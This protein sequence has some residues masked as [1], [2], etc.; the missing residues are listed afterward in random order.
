MS[1]VVDRISPSFYLFGRSWPQTEKMALTISSNSNCLQCKPIG[2]IKICYVHLY[3]QY[4]FS[5]EINIC[6]CEK[7]PGLVLHCLWGF[8]ADF[9]PLWCS[10]T[11][12][13]SS[14]HP[15][16]SEIGAGTAHKIKY[17]W[18]DKGKYLF[19]VVISLSLAPFGAPILRCIW[20][21]QHILNW[22]QNR[23]IWHQNRLLNQQR[24][25]GQGKT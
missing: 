5:L 2:D 25:I 19:N 15:H 9:R 8:Q 18:F 17:Y 22:D 20:K 3:I 6:I 23:Q 10:H 14:P 13:C 1:K 16:L 24:T 7:L 11:H 4:I 21:I 12:P